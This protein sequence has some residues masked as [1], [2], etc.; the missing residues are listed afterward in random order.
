MFR[1]AGL[2]DCGL[3]KRPLA[4][5]KLP[6]VQSRFDI[7][8]LAKSANRF[9]E[10]LDA[11]KAAAAPN[12]FPW[13]PYDSLG[14]FFLL[15][16]LLTGHHRDLAE[17][18]SGMPVLDVGCADGATAFFLEQAG[19]E[20][21]VIDNPPTN[22]NSMRGLNLLKEAFHSD[23]NIHN[24]NLDE[25]FVLPRPRYGLALFLGLLYH[26]KNPFSALET[27][28]THVRYCFL[29]TRIARWDPK[30]TSQ[31]QNV[32]V[33]YLVAPQETNNDATNFWIFSRAGLERILSRTGWEI[34][35]QHY[36]GN[37]ENSD[38]ASPEGDERAFCLVR[39]TRF[40]DAVTDY[41]LLSG[42][43]PLDA[44]NSRQTGKN[45]SF[46]LL[47]KGP[48]VKTVL[49]RF[50]VP[51]QLVSNGNECVVHV[52][53][54]GRQIGTQLYK[55]PGPKKLRIHLQQPP[56]AGQPLTVDC[57]IDSSGAGGLLVPLD[58]EPLQLI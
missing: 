3:E 9:R 44:D 56:E 53:I 58:P 43:L 18:A 26:L 29:S 35:D 38:P 37:T 33:A 1:P 23:V 24:V 17:L 39:S 5:E 47:S 20:V 45:F 19:F 22:F 15:D 8:A 41:K 13:Y 25:R 11:T 2:L 48:R 32:P 30:R 54:E 36:F 10:Q 57:R 12:D 49:L 34:C 42:W 46:Q 28:S 14:N 6:F 50:T 51:E 27:L 55:T 52:A 21:D 16:T 7:A 31:L 4:P 40:T